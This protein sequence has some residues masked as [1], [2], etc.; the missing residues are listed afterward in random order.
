MDKMQFAND[1]IGLVE[2]EN[3]R[4][5]AKSIEENIWLWKQFFQLDLESREFKFHYVENFGELYYVDM[6]NHF[7]MAIIKIT[8]M[9]YAVV[10]SNW[11]K[12]E[13]EY[14]TIGDLNLE[15]VA[16]RF[17]YLFKIKEK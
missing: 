7:R 5:R 8:K 14:F 9:E 10:I 13:V 4:Q 17:A 3:V 15:S 6:F 16:K 2:K 1:F 12:E 11:V